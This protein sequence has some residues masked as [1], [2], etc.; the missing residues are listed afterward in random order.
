MIEKRVFQEYWCFSNT[1]TFDLKSSNTNT[2]E[3]IYKK[4]PSFI[5]LYRKLMNVW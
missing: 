3:L 2:L 4:G 1:N 5:I